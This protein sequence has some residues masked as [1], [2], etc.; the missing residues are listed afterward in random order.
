MR[1]VLA[2]AGFASACGFHAVAA[3]DDA[4]RPNDDAGQ[5][6]AWRFDT[7]ADWATPGYDAL[8]MQIDDVRGSLTPVGYI[9]G[10]LLEHGE[11][12]NKLWDNAD[13]SFPWDKTAT[14][15]ASGAALW[16]GRHLDT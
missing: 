3:H 13:P 4:V 14:V 16:D 9:Y 15:T 2:V 1:V 11:R 6:V 12:G 10:G 8:A 7:G 5:A